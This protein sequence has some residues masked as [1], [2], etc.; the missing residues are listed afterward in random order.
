MI[1]IARITLLEAARRRILW[2]LA[3]VTVLSVVLTAWA[4]G[5]I[6]ALSTA[7]GNTAIQIALG[8]SQVLILA[9]FMFSFVLA[10]TAAVLAAPAIGADIESGIAQAIFA[11]PIRRSDVVLG[12]WLGLAVVVAAYA[13]AAGLGEI[14]AVRLASGY[15]PPDPLGSVAYLAAQAIV[16]MTFTL[17]LSTRL[18]TI[19]AGAVSIVAFGLGWMAGVL[20]GVGAYFGVAALGTAAD[21]SHALLPTDLLWRG[22]VFALEPPAVILALAGRGARIFQANP[23]F[24]S[25]PPEP[26]AVAWSVAWVGL[27][28]GIAIALLR[29]R[30]I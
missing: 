27:A 16:L 23:F 19:A 9:A 21:V 18:P 14:G 7:Q 2:I 5:Q 15:G 28:L 10:M 13:L 8:I 4:I 30:E 25:S 29:R 24:A 11:R 20:G 17:V 26:A 6:T 12:R 1:A 3:G 22:V